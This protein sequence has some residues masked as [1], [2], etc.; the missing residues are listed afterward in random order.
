MLHY[1]TD[2][3]HNIILC[4]IKL[5]IRATILYYAALRYRYVPQYYIMLHYVTDTCHVISNVILITKIP[6]TPN[7]VC[8]I[9][10]SSNTTQALLF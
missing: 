1:V 2:T 4:C 5:P 8:D 3:Y 10:V 7:N 9:H 6:A